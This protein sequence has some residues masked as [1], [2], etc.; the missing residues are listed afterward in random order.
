M[1]RGCAFFICFQLVFHP[2][3]HCPLRTGGLL[4]GQNLLIVT[5]DICRQS[6]KVYSVLTLIQSK[7]FVSY[8][9]K[10]KCSER[11]TRNGHQRIFRKALTDH[12]Y[13]HTEN[14]DQNINFYDSDKTEIS[15]HFYKSF[16]TF[17]NV[18]GGLCTQ[19]FHSWPWVRGDVKSF[20]L[21]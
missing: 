11:G 3:L 14:I 18:F 8:T 20:I 7:Y 5:K 13:I 17:Q 6:L 19:V 15:L 9:A 2:F 16:L 1:Q 12:I 21:S 10:K 4:N